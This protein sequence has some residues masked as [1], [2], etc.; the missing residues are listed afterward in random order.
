MEQQEV[1]ALVSEHRPAVGVSYPDEVKRTVIAYLNARRAQGVALQ[2]VSAEVGLSTTTLQVWRRQCTAFR[3]VTI[4][5][6][7]TSA[8]HPAPAA[9]E[10]IVLHT[11]EGFR[12]S[13]LDL[14][15]AIAALRVLR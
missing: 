2:D 11:P 12:L 7:P 1:R 9:A 6:S 3:P 15:Q 5:E 10:G 13:G 14:E 4:V 8:V